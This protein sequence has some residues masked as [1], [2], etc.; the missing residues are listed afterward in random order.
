MKIV[1]GLPAAATVE[2]VHELAIAGAGEFF[3]GYVPTYW[4]QRFG[5]EFSPNR[6]Y[7]AGSQIDSLAHLKSLCKAAAERNVPVAITFNEHFVTPRAMEL[8]RKLLDEALA[9]GCTSI[10]V[11]DPSLVPFFRTELPAI[12]IHVSGDAGLYNRIACEALFTSGA[13]RVIFPRELPLTELTPIMTEVQ[14]PAREFEAFVMGE[15]CVFD[16]AR[17][18]TEHGYG[19]ECD[20]CNHHKRKYVRRRNSSS[21]HPLEPP[22][23][24]LLD[25]PKNRA[26]W[27]LGKC[28]LCAISTLAAQGV[29]HVKIPGRASEALPAIRLVKSL[30]DS[31]DQSPRAAQ[32]LLDSPDLCASRAFCYFP[33]VHDD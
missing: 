5:Q 14:G 27:G 20:F 29:T 3:L 10:I 1:A 16:G 17:C 33:E 13:K 6:R 24:G 2:E 12:D 4:S 28:G 19:F 23:A 25:N 8:G 7:F 11:A 32:D 15:P 22:Q 9:A 30:L 31:S 21:R 18:F 26:I